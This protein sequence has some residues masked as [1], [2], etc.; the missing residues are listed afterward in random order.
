[1]QFIGIL[2]GG[3]IGYGLV[4]RLIMFVVGKMWPA[5]RVLICHL[6]SYPLA[7]L[8]AGFGAADGGPFVWTAGFNY[9]IPASLWVAIDIVHQRRKYRSD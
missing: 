6:I 3:F 2:I 5:H 9:L 7:H 4:S 8:I 1:M